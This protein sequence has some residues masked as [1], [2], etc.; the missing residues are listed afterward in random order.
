MF[1][2][3]PDWLRFVAIGVFIGGAVLAFLYFM[4]RHK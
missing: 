1:A 2:E 4:L 3:I